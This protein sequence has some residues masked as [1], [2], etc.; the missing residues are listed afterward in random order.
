MLK[1]VLYRP[2]YVKVGILPVL[3]GTAVVRRNE[4]GD[5]VLEVNG[6]HQG[7][8]RFRK[9]H[10]VVLL[11]DSQQIM[12]GA[13]TE[14]HKSFTAGVRTITL[15][16]KSDMVWLARRVTFP[17]PAVAADS[18]TA[19]AYYKRSGNAETLIRDMV[20][21]NVGP[22]A[23]A[24]RRE[25][26]TMDPNGNRGGQVALNSR[27]KNVLEE[28]H[29]LGL[30][31]DV[32]FETRQELGTSAF[33]FRDQRDLTRHIRL[34][35]A[36]GGVT[37]YELGETAPEVTDVIVAGQGEGTARTIKVREGNAN[38]WGVK[39]E[40]F[41]DRRDTDDENEL[42]QAGDERLAE[43]AEAASVSLE[44]GDTDRYRF[45]TNFHLGDRIT[46]NLGDDGVIQDLV[47]SAEID[48]SEDGRRVKLQVGPTLDE[49]DAPRWKQAF[50]RL[51]RDV[52]GL[53]A[54]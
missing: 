30:V 9:G 27:F 18:Q 17:D 15:K 5:F 53:K 22:D 23:R 42:D 52:G 31:G 39:A 26:L 7:W 51:R 37:A 11:D 44:I 14:A 47:Q 28:A 40:E 46:V 29:A 32:T 49:E 20:R 34:S 13:I 4:V 33:G 25:T 16:G 2:D 50:D 45:A 41:R 10:R 48:W 21:L 36:N 6:N 1:A 8:Q 38:D 24:E 12:A 35:P 3:S 54:V 43:G 19:S